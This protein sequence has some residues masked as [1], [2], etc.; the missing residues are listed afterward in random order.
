MEMNGVPETHAHDKENHNAFLPENKVELTEA[1]LIKHK[2]KI[3][4]ALLLVIATGYTAMVI[5]ACIVNFDQA[6]LL[7]VITS[8]VVFFLAWDWLMARYGDL[9]YQTFS[10][11]A[12]YHV[13]FIQ[14][15][16]LK[17]GFLMLVTMDTTSTESLAAAGGVF[18]GQAESL[19]L[20]RP[21][22]GLLTKSEIH[23]VLTCGFASVS[24][25]ILPAYI[26]MGVDSSH[27]LTA[28]VLSGPA[29]LAIA[30][31]FWPE[32][33]TIQVNQEMKIAKGESNNLLEAIADG[34][35]ASVPVVANVVVCLIAFISILAFLDA[36]LSWLGALFQYPQLSFSLICAYLFSPLAFMLGVAWEDSFLVGELIGIKIFL[37]E[38]LAY[39]KMSEL[40]KLREE[41]APEYV[42]NVK[43]YISFHSEIIATYTLSGFSNLSTLGMTIGVMKTLAPERK[44]D[45]IGCSVRA[46]IAGNVACFMTA[47]IAG[48][49][50]SFVSL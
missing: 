14:W 48:V 42:D 11:V 36:T 10:P 50:Y 20:I 31:V 40:V 6:V 45:F 46:L 28:S 19:L 15:M 21:Y 18:L 47:C 22:I 2:D 16:V 32:T 38:L 9:L 1:C 30:E 12:L 29:S 39:E 7:L 13:G 25:A 4:L 23:S 37:N 35:R 8:I 17:V 43:Q 44:A 41:G 49:F 33:E 5:A 27:L 24:A 34:A 3:R 26:T